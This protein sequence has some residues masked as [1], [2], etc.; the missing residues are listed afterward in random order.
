MKMCTLI[1]TCLIF[2]ICSESY[3][4]NLSLYPGKSELP[5]LPSNTQVFVHLTDFPITLDIFY[6]IHCFGLSFKTSL[7]H[8]F[9]FP[10]IVKHGGGYGWV[11]GRVSLA[12]VTKLHFQLSRESIT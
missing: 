12:I 11:G 6:E 1:K 7:K 3:L 8:N 2:Y 5:F 4:A 10:E 9:F